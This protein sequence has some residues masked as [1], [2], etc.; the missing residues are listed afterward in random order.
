MLLILHT[1][2]VCIFMVMTSRMLVLSRILSSE[3][4]FSIECQ[5]IL[6]L[7]FQRENQFQQS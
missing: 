7:P 3:V 2:T 6:Y 1:T 5:V 4:T